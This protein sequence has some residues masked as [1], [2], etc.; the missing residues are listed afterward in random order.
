MDLKIH[1]SFAQ[2]STIFGKEIVEHYRRIFIHLKLIIPSHFKVIVCNVLLFVF[3]V[4]I[5]EICLIF[6]G[7]SSK[8][9]VY[10]LLSQDVEGWLILLFEIKNFLL[11]KNAYNGI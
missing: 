11:A 7:N 5:L 1:K 10:L 9:C 6:L 3:L 2:Q 4:K 8:M